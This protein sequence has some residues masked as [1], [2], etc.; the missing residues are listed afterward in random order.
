MPTKFAAKSNLPRFVMEPRAWVLV[1]IIRFSGNCRFFFIV[2]KTYHFFN[3]VTT[4]L[5]YPTI[6]TICRFDTRSAAPLGVT[7]TVQDE[8]H[9]GEACRGCTKRRCTDVPTDDP[10]SQIEKFPQNRL[11]TR[12]TV[13]LVP[14]TTIYSTSDNIPF[15]FCNSSTPGV[16]PPTSETHPDTPKFT[17]SHVHLTPAICML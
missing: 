17:W 11:Q 15:F 13:G 2:P 14:K 6:T 9:A 3:W 1:G 4:P 12:K 16:K 5:T 8:K 10:R 7:S